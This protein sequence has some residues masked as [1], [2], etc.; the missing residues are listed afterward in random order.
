[1]WEAVAKAL[2]GCTK[3]VVD[4]PEQ[5]PPPVVFNEIHVTVERRHHHHHK[6]RRQE[7]CLD[8]PALARARPD[9]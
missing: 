2:W 5:T 3:R 4:G 6:L 8:L 1:M 9:S 7:A